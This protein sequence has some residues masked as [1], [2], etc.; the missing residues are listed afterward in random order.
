MLGRHRMKPLSNLGT[1]TGLELELED[2]YF[3]A[4]MEKNQEEREK[5]RDGVYIEIYM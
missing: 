2:K 4:L 3:E 1:T 5:G